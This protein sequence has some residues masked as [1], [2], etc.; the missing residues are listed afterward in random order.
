MTP[1]KWCRVAMRPQG[2]GIAGL[3][4]LDGTR[5]SIP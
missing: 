3:V 5:E 2:R 4:T 1:N